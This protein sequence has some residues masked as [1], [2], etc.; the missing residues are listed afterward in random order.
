MTVDQVDRR[1]EILSIRFGQ[2]PVLV[3]APLAGLVTT[4][5]DAGRGYAGVGSP[6]TT[7]WLFPGHLPGRPLTAARLGERLGRLGIDARAGR[8]AAL[9]HLAARLPAAV[10]AELLHISPG[11]AVGWVHHAAGDWSS[12]AA[13]LARDRSHQ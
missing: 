6:S 4:L 8:R 2:E 1:D 11:T 3:P 10:L 5:I 9:T 12:Y 13:H 7:R